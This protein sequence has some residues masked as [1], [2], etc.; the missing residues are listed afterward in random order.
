MPGATNGTENLRTQ[1]LSQILKMVH[2]HGPLPRSELTR[3]S[4]FNRSTVGALVAALSDRGLV[5][6][7]DPPVAGRVGRP[8]PIVT[9]NEK[10]A[11][12]SINP[13]IDA[14]TIGLVGLGGH[15]HRR[16]RLEAAEVPSL[17]E[18]VRMSES[19]RAELQPDIETMDRLLG[20]GIALPGL[21]N[22]AAGRVLLA[23]HLGWRDADLTGPFSGALGLPA[24]AANDAALGSLAESIFGAALGVENVLY[25]N[26][27]ASGIGGGVIAGG[28]QLRGGLGYAGELGHTLV[29]T[30]GAGCHCGRQGCLDAE[31]RL[32]RLLRAGGL[33]RGG[34]DRLE[35]L[36]AEPSS[37]AL[38]IEVRRQLALLAVALTNFVNIF[39]PEVIV[40]GGF[41][42]SIFAYDD[43]WLIGTVNDRALVGGV[44]IRRA[45]LGPELLLVGAAE[46]VFEPL[47][48]NP[49]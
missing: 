18:A 30:G 49:A 31:V 12:L 33:D 7:T 17:A 14:M 2:Q 22:V 5:Y 43:D 23:P 29:Q 13:D 34:T 16:I 8:S 21:V 41:L 39:D 26:G 25:L 42:G 45:A 35:N 36:L 38:R 28:A 10:V 44:T 19:I 6:E 1:N 24:R 47:L 40:L 11:A 9:A 46:L 48:L 27:S 15:V 32:E 4:G 3:R 37:D 20:I